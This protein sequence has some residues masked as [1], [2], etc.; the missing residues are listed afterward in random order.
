MEARGFNSLL[1]ISYNKSFEWY[2]AYTELQPKSWGVHRQGCYD[3]ND[4]NDMQPKPDHVSSV[5]MTG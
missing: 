4:H 2:S 1:E 3:L 5:E